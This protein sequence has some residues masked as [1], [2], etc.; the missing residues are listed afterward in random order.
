MENFWL[1][2]NQEN[3]MYEISPNG[4]ILSSFCV[5]DN[6]SLEFDNSK[7]WDP[8]PKE[9]TYNILCNLKLNLNFPKF[10]EIIES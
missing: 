1:P 10:W 6:I 4:T 5:P 3:K 9:K 7:L 8:K 2:D